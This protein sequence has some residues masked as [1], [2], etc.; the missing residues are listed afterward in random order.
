[1]LHHSTPTKSRPSWDGTSP[2]NTPVLHFF[3]F[4]QNNT[5]AHCA[6]L[7]DSKNAW[8]LLLIDDPVKPLTDIKVRSV[9]NK[10]VLA[11]AAKAYDKFRNGG[12]RVNQNTFTMEQV[13]AKMRT[14]KSDIQ[15]TPCESEFNCTLSRLENYIENNPKQPMFG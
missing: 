11:R 7:E 9:L 2:W 15:I 5:I 1:M 4:E 3:W 10:S 8:I 14:M 12:L 6:I 13:R